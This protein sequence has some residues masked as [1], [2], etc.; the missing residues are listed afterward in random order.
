MAK[1]NHWN[2]RV[3]SQK[4]RWR[5]WELNRGRSL[6]SEAS[7]VAQTGRRREQRRVAASARRFRQ[8]VSL[9]NER[10]RTSDKSHEHARF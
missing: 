2:A 7:R 10:E 6:T 5:Q 3:R 8:L 1:R 9:R 4:S